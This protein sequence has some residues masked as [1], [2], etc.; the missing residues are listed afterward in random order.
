[1]NGVFTSHGALVSVI[2]GGR[3]ARTRPS[4]G[5]QSWMRD[6][7]RSLSELCTISLVAAS[8]TDGTFTNAVVL[9]YMF[10]SQS[11]TITF[12]LCRVFGIDEHMAC[13]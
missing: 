12:L 3:E 7:S 5:E 10:S 6:V 11:S 13:C 2:V 8:P 1:M 4:L 9:P